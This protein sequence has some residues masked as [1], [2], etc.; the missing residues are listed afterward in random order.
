MWVSVWASVEGVVR[1]I[2]DASGAGIAVDHTWPC[3]LERGF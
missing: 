2:R 3:Q 1:G